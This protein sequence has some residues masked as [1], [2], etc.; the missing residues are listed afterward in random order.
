MAENGEYRVVSN[1]FVFLVEQYVKKRFL[2]FSWGKWYLLHSM[3]P[4]GDF[5]QPKEFNT[6]KEAR[7]RIKELKKQDEAESKKHPFVEVPEWPRA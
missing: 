3:S 1:G 5:D 4:D 6:E 7:D 2:F